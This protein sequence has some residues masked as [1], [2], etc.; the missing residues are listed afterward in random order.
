MDTLENKLAIIKETKF[1]I[2]SIEKFTR[3]FTWIK[4]AKKI[5]EA[6]DKEVSHRG[7]ALMSDEDIKE[8]S[9]GDFKIQKIDPTEIDEYSP[10]SVFEAFGEDRALPLMKVNGSALKLYLKMGLKNGA[11]SYEE[12][13]KC[14]EGMVKK[15]KKG[16]IKLTPK[17]S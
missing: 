11:V 14:K 15:M 6:F 3:A 5:I 12:C 2:T 13:E 4:Q 16:F 8:L 9:I 1:E 7:F 17:K 10:R